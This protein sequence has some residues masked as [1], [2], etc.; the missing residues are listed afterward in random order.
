MNYRFQKTITLPEE[1]QQFLKDNV[2]KY[3]LMELAKQLNTSKSKV[4]RCLQLMGIDKQV[5]PK[6]NSF[7]RNGY[8]DVDIFGKMYNF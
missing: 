4:G 3:S 8:F 5:N 2:N 7:E 6:Y 1:Q